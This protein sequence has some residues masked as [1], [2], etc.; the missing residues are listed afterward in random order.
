MLT[1]KDNIKSYLSFSLGP[2]ISAGISLVTT[3][4]ITW[5]INPSEY[6]IAQMFNT[7]YVL[8]FLVATS[9]IE[10]GFIR[11]Y[12]EIDIKQ[13]AVLFRK[14][15]K[16]SLVVII[17]ESIIILAAW[18]NISYLIL[19]DESFIIAL[20]LL[21][22][23]IIGS[24]NYFATTLVR[25]NNKGVSF[26]LI[27]ILQALTNSLLIILISIC[28]SDTYLSVIVA[29]LFSFLFSFMLAV[30]F[31]RRVWFGYSESNF[32]FD[33]KKIIVYGIPFFPSLLIYQAFNFVDRFSIR[34][35][36]DINSLGIYSIA[37]KF[38][39]IFML[40]QKSFGA[41]WAPIA[42]KAYSEEKCNYKYFENIF[43][44]LS[45]ILFASFSIMLSLKDILIF[46]LNEKYYESVNIFP[47]LMFVPIMYMLSEVTVLGINFSKN[48]YWHIFISISCLII[49]VLTHV[50]MVPKFG[51]KGAAFATGLSFI[52]FFVLRT[53]IS[54]KYYFADYKIFK[55]IITVILLYL[56]SAYVTFFS[57]E[58]V[59]YYFTAILL[60]IIY[61]FYRNEIY[62]FYQQL[63]LL[64]K[65]TKS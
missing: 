23:I 5:L 50:S 6:G 33:M 32:M 11:Y 9:T 41:F 3:P 12:Y 14:C 48:T 34:Y 56:A 19:N 36:S 64:I 8:A 20:L 43:F 37:F 24:M 65:K 54:S 21:G 60:I 42:Y 47:C 31:E 38:T 4:I 25:M 44:L 61:I 53:V 51:A 26:S 45:I 30:Y 46:I 40:M 29:Q 7:V 1:I 63:L 39:A 22:T 55:T 10:Q 58:N 27:Y 16:Y 62:F 49:N 15:I 52:A 17:F 13:R 28:V 35:F 2:W 18:K 57:E 59:S